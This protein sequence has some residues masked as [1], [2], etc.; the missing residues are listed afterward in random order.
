MRKSFLLAALLTATLTSFGQK[1]NDILKE[2]DDY[3]V[4]T[5]STATYDKN[6]SDVWSAIYVVAT[7][8][9]NTI[10]RES[11]SKGYIE[12][13]TELE[14]TKRNLTIEIKGDKAPYRVS[15]Q[16]KNEYRIKNPDNTYTNW[17][18][19]VVSP[20]YIN[21]LQLRV[22]ELI[23]GAIVLPAD[24]QNKIDNYNKLQTKDRLKIVKGK[25]Y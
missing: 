20:K 18:N 1:K 11:E 16:V 15:F 17:S 2:I 19:N 23:N 4:K 12:A 14:L 10:V 24:L 22:Y 3:I 21:K 5:V 8:E 6:Y 25:D 13:K 7:E 9:C